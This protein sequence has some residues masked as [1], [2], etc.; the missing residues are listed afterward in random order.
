V[1]G[2]DHG[3]DN[4]PRRIYMKKELNLIAE[5]YD[6]LRI[7]FGDT[8]VP[9]AFC[10]LFCGDNEYDFSADTDPVLAASLAPFPL[11][12]AYG[13]AYDLADPEDHADR[14]EAAAYAVARALIC[15]SY[16]TQAPGEPAPA[17]RLRTESAR[18]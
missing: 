18:R 13:W 12:P 15:L 3:T 5:A 4:D 11:G 2:A 6:E 1:A 14:V 17:A 9:P 16:P 7:P 10:D 8:W